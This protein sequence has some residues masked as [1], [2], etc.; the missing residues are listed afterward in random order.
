[1]EIPSYARKLRGLEIGRL[2]PTRQSVT[3]PLFAGEVITLEGDR[4]GY[5]VIC[6]KGRLWITQEN[7]AADYVLE[8]GEEFVI[9]KSGAVVIQGVQKSKARIQ[10]PGMTVDLQQNA[11]WPVS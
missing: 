8:E 10:P 1:M 11:P 7:D 2:I 5:Q 4:S 9:S 3:V 6:Q